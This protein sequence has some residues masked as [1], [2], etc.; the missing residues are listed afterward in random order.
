M[1]AME[2]IARLR[3]K[4][5][6][7]RAVDGKLE[8]DAPRGAIDDELRA[9]IMTH[10]P[11]LLRLLSWSRRSVQAT[12]VALEPVSR[13]SRLPLSW[14][15][16]RLWFLD[17]LEPGS[18]A[19]NIS[20]TVRLRGQLDAGALHAAFV[21]VLQRHEAL[22]TVFPAEDGEP[23]QRVVETVDLLLQRVDARGMSEEQ[24]RA[25][26]S[27]LA[28][29]RFNLAD[30]LLI[31]PT[32]LQLA[33]EEHILLVVVHHIVADGASM[34]ILFRELAAFYETGLDVEPQNLAALPVQYADY[35][36]WQRSWLDSTEL[37]RQSAYWQQ[38]LAGLPPLLELPTDRPR[39]AAMRYRGA[40]VLRVLPAEL[41]A[42]LRQ[43][44]R[45]SG[46]TL[47]M[48]M[49]SAFY[50]LLM[51]Y[52]GREDLVVGTPLGG[53]SRTSLEGLIGFFINTVVLRAD[54][55][56]NPP[57]SELL[58]RVRDVALEAHSNQDLPFEKLVELLQPEREL[59]FSP[60][61]QV[62]FDL[63]E[64]PRWKLPVRSLEV[65]PEVV[66]SSRTSSFDL[67]L[68]VR[69]AEQGLDAMFEYD[70]DL[71]DESSIEAL[72][73]RY[74]TL[75]EAIVTDP[76]TRIA[77]L[78]LTDPEEEREQ[79]HVWHTAHR[80][81]P[82][83]ATLGELYSARA[84]MQPDAE[85]LHDGGRTYSYAELDQVANGVA[86]RLRDA[87]VGAD[88]PVAVCAR[89]SAEAV[90]AMLSVH[91]AGGCVVPLDPAY[92]AERLRFMLADS[93][94]AV[95]VYQATDTALAESLVTGTG[96]R[97]LVLTTAAC[98]PGAGI[99][100]VPPVVAGARNLA[101]L[102]YTSGTS[103]TPKGVQL[104]HR[105]L[106]NYVLQLAELTGLEAGD[107][108]LQFASPGFDIA[109]EETMTALLSGA[110][111]VVREP[112]MSQSVADFCA[113]CQRHGITWLSLP[114]AWW[115][116][117]CEALARN[118]VQLPA[119]LRSVVVGGEKA[120]LEAFRKWH[121]AAGQVRLF[122]TYG[123]TETSI[124]AAWTELTH[125]DPG[126]LGEVPLGYPVPNA[127]VWIMDELL[128]PVPPGL[129]G[130]ICIGGPGLA[131]AYLNQADLTAARFV[132]VRLPDATTERLYRTGDRARYVA[133]HGLLF[134]GRQDEQIK[135]RGHRI[136]PAEIEAV[137]AALP[138]AGRCAVIA[139][140]K[141]ASRQ[142][143]A[144][145][146]GHADPADLHQAL[147]ETLPDYMVPAAV[148]H[149]ARLPF[150]AN[151]KLDRAALPKPDPAAMC[152][153]KRRSPATETQKQLAAIWAAVLD[154]GEP[155]IDDDFFVLGGHSLI[156]TRVM[157][158]VR[159]HFGVA[160]PLRALFD[161]PTV[162]QLAVVIDR[163]AG[164]ADSL[165]LPAH[166]P[167]LKLASLSWS[168]QRLWVLD[169]LEP[170][171][172]AYHLYTASELS[173]L[174]DPVAL[175][176]ALDVLAA[177]H[178]AL[179]TVFA[180]H[181]GEAVQIVREAM[182]IELQR[183]QLPDVGR[184]AIDQLLQALIDEPFEL[185]AGPLLRA[186]LCEL[187][188]GRCVL[189]LVMHHIIADGWS[190][191]VLLRELQ[192]VYR[193]GEAA[194]LPELP[195][196]YADYACWQ[197][198]MLDDGHLR[199][200]EK[201]W[202]Q[203]LADL[204][205]LMP[206]P[207]DY[208][209]PATQTHNGAWV[210]LRLSA[211]QLG[212][213][214]QTAGEHASSLFMVLLTAF[215]ATLWRHTGAADLI[216]GTPVAGRTRTELE[217]LVG[218]FLN[219]LVLRTQPGNDPSFAELLAAVRRTTLD[220]YEHQALPFERL[221]DMLQPPRTPAYTPL[222]QVLF[223]LHNERGDNLALPGLTAA[224]MLL[225][226]AAAKFDLS[227]SV[228][229]Q[230]DGLLIGFEC[231]S[232]LFSG[233]TMDSLLQHYRTMLK[234]ICTDVGQP[235]AR[236]ALPLAS[237]H[238][239]VASSTP[240]YVPAHYPSVIARFVEVAEQFADA[241]A[242]RDRD[243][244]CSYRELCRW[245]AAVAAAL[246]TDRQAEPSLIGL[247]VGHD[248]AA[249]AGLLG[250]LRAGGAY[251]PLDPE[252]P[253]ARIREIIATAGIGQVLA[254]AA[255]LAAATELCGDAARVVCMPEP[256]AI[257]AAR[258]DTTGQPGLA[259]VLF[260]SGTTGVPKG[261]MQTHANVLQH[262]A[263]YS[264]SVAI[265]PQD[266]LAQFARCG[267]DAA[268]MDIFG[269]LLN[270]AC[271]SLIDV[272][273]M[274]DD[275]LAT[276]M[277]GVSVLHATPSVF[278]FVSDELRDTEALARVRA[279]VLGGEETRGSDFE[280]FRNCYRD[281]AVFINGLGPSESTMALQFCASRDARLPGR[282]V[283][284]GH[285][286]PGTDVLLLDKDGRQAG[287][288][289][290]IVIRSPWVSPGYLQQPELTATRMRDGL[291]YTGDLARRL[292][293]GALVYEGR[294]DAQ[295]QIN[296]RRTEPGEVELA[297]AALDGVDR[298]AVLVT[299]QT[300]VACYS[301]SAEEAGLR[302]ML[303]A[304]LP[305]WMVPARLVQLPGLPLRANGKV[306]RDALL[307]SLPG[308]AA[309]DFTAP[310]D[311]LERTIAAL[312][313]E[314]LSVTRVSVTDDF[315]ALGGHSLLAM[316]LLA[317]I[318][319]Q[320][321]V[322]LALANVFAART[323]AE[324]A[325]HVRAL[326]Q[327]HDQQLQLRRRDGAALPP[328][329]WAQQ[330]LWFL[331]RLEPDSAA[332]NLHWAARLSNEPDYDCLQ[333]AL[334]DVMRRHES[335][336]T[337]FIDHAGE[338]VQLVHADGV[339]PL[340]VE[341]MQ[342]AGEAALNRRM[343][344]LIRESFD[345]QALPLIRAYVFSGYDGG[346][347]LLLTLHHIVADGWSM[348]VLF[349]DLSAC[350]AARTLG[351]AADLPELPVQYAD[352]ALWQRDWLQ[353]AELERQRDFWS[354]HLRDMPA[355]LELPLDHPRPPVQRYR[356]AWVNTTFSAELLARLR[357]L[358]DAHSATL[359]MVVLAVFKVLLLRH[360][361]RRDIVVGAPVAGRG[362]AA[363]ERL[364]GYF[365]NTLVLRTAVDADA[366][367]TEVLAAV[368]DTTL[369]AYDHQDL[370]FEKLLELLQPTR[371]TAHAPLVQV[372]I[373]LHNEPGGSLSLAGIDADVL[374]VD[375]GTSK[376][377]LSLSL[378]ESAAG[379]RAGFEYNTDLFTAA[380][381]RIILQ[382]FGDLLE[383]FAANPQQSVCEP[384]LAAAGDSVSID[385][386]YIPL[387]LDHDAT[388]SGMFA[389]AA[390]LHAGNAAVLMPGMTLTYAALAA[391]ADAVAATV[392]AALP[393][394]ASTGQQRIALLLGHDEHAIAALMGVLQA[395]HIYVPLDHQAP[396]ARLQQILDIARPS[397]VI[398]DRVHRAALPAACDVACLCIE[399]VVAH[400]KPEP[401]AIAPD[402]LAYLL[403]T[404]GT[405]GE[406]KAVMQTH[407]NILKHIR[408]Y[409]DA[410]CI[411]PEDRLTWFA[412]L[413]FDAAV[414]DVYGALLNG[415]SLHPFE[416]RAENYPGETLDRMSDAAVTVLHATPTVFRFLMRSKV[417]RHELDAVR[418]VVLGGEEAH[419]SDFELFRRQFAPPA[420]FVNGLGPSEST[421]AA[422]YFAD[423]N[424][425][426][427]G[428]MVP[429]GAAVAGTELQLLDESGN[430]TALQ[431]ELAIV[432]DGIAPGY[433]NDAALT[434][435]RFRRLDDGRTEYRT[436]D[437]ARRLPGGQLVFTG[438]LD[439][440]I[441]LRGVRIEPAEIEAVLARHEA[442]RDAVV[443]LHRDSYTGD[444]RLVA[445]FTG[446][447]EAAPL[448]RWLR[449][450]L[451][452]FMV[453]S[454]CV[455]LSELPL[456][457][458]G[459]LDRRRLPEPGRA[460]D[461]TGGFVP[462]RTETEQ[463]L[464]RIWADVLGVAKVGV[465]DDFFDL[466]GHS[467]LAAQLT[468]RV[469]ESMQVTVPLRRLF[470][471]PT[472][473]AIAAHIDNMRWVS[474]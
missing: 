227:V 202:T 243:D 21:R 395:G 337:C 29:C 37:D 317:R 231:N 399:D 351:R 79:V 454:V 307:A 190:V 251:V 67:T 188:N 417:C 347:V 235:I 248:A 49:L 119:Q 222:V 346:A 14:A 456:T 433:W 291:Y 140:G 197:R 80:E 101:Y 244:V 301:G 393:T 156:A 338:P 97:G 95:L 373:N 299:G 270:G 314:L 56:G 465:H 196:T 410:L 218:C 241:P 352:Y 184:E 432:S 192:A 224:P 280:I 35:A 87:G 439:D 297:L 340:R 141:G 169:A 388:V 312:Y 166:S 132:D 57:F 288:R 219:T 212:A 142:L 362:H 348:G 20:W 382:Q 268:V 467:L 396:P 115:H 328:L 60:V 257:A 324:L 442:V 208:E 26:L 329:S 440:Q 220:A 38:Q 444:A 360:T 82:A 298:C 151:G 206:L 387:P 77:E 359:F 305:S 116:E 322:R 449:E 201:Y 277:R 143:V 409:S 458:N 327:E 405:T 198:E 33:D 7:L 217:G 283:P 420:V 459:K 17:Q 319:A 391:R 375:R 48:T 107:R 3:D 210:S 357:A 165:P 28:A 237:D 172:T 406:P 278:R 293:D 426:L 117:L 284:V 78:P 250:I 242:V 185:A 187:Q 333:A 265:G 239:P 272:T 441:K 264:A 47:F 363:T 371:S 437:G 296:G 161:N 419:R 137:L 122:N 191:G 353:G 266:L 194:V 44:S 416:L 68:S 69:Q 8:V 378:V 45:D 130:E 75:L 404:S 164:V 53:R 258:S 138:D 72:A 279:V 369:S 294:L 415:A 403:F 253:A 376:F 135:L 221:L 176:A 411:A 469:N 427:P 85:A 385:R 285:A 321:P 461:E 448:R 126:H 193:D 398:T 275:A 195:L 92:P 336:R 209:R 269:A 94:A 413:G 2:L 247:C 73:L 148:M 174:P 150:T 93:A 261:V 339:V 370:P 54:L 179:R 390:A 31:R 464:A 233:A 147:R 316:R 331:D 18:P 408:S 32:L 474:Q 470:D 229:E 183:R 349:D 367:F 214:Q 6:R 41:A 302:A 98:A 51:R 325:A 66:F 163:Q 154:I 23:E 102:M 374:T 186:V 434:A 356:G 240:A 355:L 397:L 361:G 462:P 167:E 381:I 173:A 262:A 15:Q 425:V 236:V 50:V 429:I 62:M 238:A 110:T 414:M 10:K 400:R 451:P 460:A 418:A 287:I 473:G 91:K 175:Q 436:G 155:G 96:C 162:E 36:V 114:T 125:L 274:Q 289:G 52:S 106:V 443:I 153:G 332:Y 112:A 428:G 74:Q 59:S 263:T 445:Y 308:P 295:V 24:L 178:P 145:S 171:S 304:V 394:P 90:I 447:A 204:P 136:E 160:V 100:A 455:A 431:G 103:G 259:Y 450:Q 421:L 128:R 471:E 22:R 392:Q 252:L 452:E 256:D 389:R 372:T 203:Q 379:L 199:N 88:T 386:P 149:V 345:L 344:E 318:N 40:A 123:P 134:L 225:D 121:A 65:V 453:P 200:A 129:P 320:L 4:G 113:G 144:Y 146:S 180:E 216:V 226:R 407:S 104:E 9:E 282:Q 422:Q 61:F 380:T 118:D 292:P 246:Q 215:K 27:Q 177:R 230:G 159:D 366:S 468:A 16:Q 55:S 152:G 401:A 254:D 300:L 111:L 89:H 412:T 334:N 286:V 223:N 341:D 207:V 189:L 25:R 168:Q 423:H 364:I 228:A 309:A 271:L 383:A 46:C 472:V 63:Q 124:A 342:G 86:A 245:S 1:T 99:A 64:E 249:I 368:R 120:A 315:F 205:P 84:A 281:D 109:I 182:R 81:Y 358:A 76:A 131:R 306:D 313:S 70:T 323:V 34:R 211:E 181:N 71:F 273:D 83:A 42:Q 39:A 384:A 290:E 260:T 213:L 424:S 127:Q 5:I 343:L 12:G 463:Q 457:A 158:R 303:Q 43:V 438:R 310:R 234:A 267:Y 335:L 30:E 326:P 330:R 365:L 139:R 232:D 350:Y 255:H 446:T 402:D 108:V 170:D 311:S 105:G 435:R 58:Q 276:A 11:D 19:Y 430:P 157:A 13:E 354:E 133:D 377:D 466:G